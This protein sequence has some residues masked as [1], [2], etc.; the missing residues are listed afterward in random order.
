MNNYP[1]S[2]FQIV[3]KNIADKF[4]I[5]SNK[6]V[7]I[8]GAT[9]MIGSVLVD[10]LRYVNKN[11]NK[12][13][14]IYAMSRKSVR[15]SQRFGTESDLLT[16][17]E[18]DL[19]QPFSS[20][21]HIDYIIHAGGLN[22][23]RAF[24]NTPVQTMKTTLVGTM[25]MLDIAVRDNA[26]ITFVSSGEV[27]GRKSN[28]VFSESDVGCVDTKNPRSCYPESKR[29]AETLCV[30]YGKQY[31]TKFNV[32]RLGYIY[33]PTITDTSDLAMAE[34]LRD[35]ADGKNIVLKSDGAQMRS[36]LYVMD[37]I[38]GILHVIL[39]GTN[40][41]FYN[42]AGEHASLREFAETFAN[43]AGV[44]VETGNTPTPPDSD[45]VITSEKLRQIGW[46]PAH[47]L[48][49]GL[50]QTYIARKQQITK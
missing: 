13:V 8:T 46:Q 21:T 34:F 47:T 37:A 41:E 14:H 17:I 19:S 22:G 12:N 10:F 42:I 35:V 11:Y 43:V 1:H 25:S 16:F 20:N 24:T 3:Y 33:G 31:G 45:S 44:G 7:L 27:Y 2:E 40:G 15:L 26:H 39:H 30:S 6:S 9:G 48:R 38:S 32:V 29:A 49:D 28:H 4:D 18:H 36:W 23:P 50:I 5:L